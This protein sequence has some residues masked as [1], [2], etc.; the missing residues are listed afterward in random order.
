MF[1]LSLFFACPIDRTGQSISSVM[2]SDIQQNKHQLEKIE[3]QLLNYEQ[4]LAQ[5]ENITKARGEADLMKLESIEQVRMELAN[6]RNDLDIAKH[7]SEQNTEQITTIVSDS[8][9]RLGWLE[10]RADQIEA[11]LGFATPPPPEFPTSILPTN[12]ISKNPNETKSTDPSQQNSTVNLTENDVNSATQDA[13]TDSL[14]SMENTN[15]LSSEDLIK[16]IEEHLSNNRLVAADALLNVFFSKYGDDKGMPRALYRHAEVAYNGG[17]YKT[18]TQRFQKVLDYE[19][20]TPFKPWAMYRQGEC[21]ES[22]EQ[23]ENAAIFYEDV[24]QKYPKSKAALE[25]TAKLQ[26]QKSTEKNQKSDSEEKQKPKN[27]KE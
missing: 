22:M 27:K 1:L 11:Q 3:Q 16:K 10:E 14:T 13:Q 7:A 26:L 24:I 12:S 2:R 15:Q 6:F 4:R 8:T 25:A 18:A 20:Q 9:F 21:F 19:G 17:D 23:P 5:I